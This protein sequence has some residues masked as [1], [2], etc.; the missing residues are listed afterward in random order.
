MN[1]A[2]APPAVGEAIIFK[3][4][5]SAYEWRRQRIRNPIRQIAPTAYEWGGG[6]HS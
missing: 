6:P 1:S 2:L 3:L 5:K 4:R